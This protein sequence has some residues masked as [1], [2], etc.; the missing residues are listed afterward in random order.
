M[1]LPRYIQHY[2]YACAVL[3]ASSSNTVYAYYARMH[4]NKY[5]CMHTKATVAGHSSK[6]PAAGY[7]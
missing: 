7:Y 3:L 4:S 1:D 2:T 5:S 6:R